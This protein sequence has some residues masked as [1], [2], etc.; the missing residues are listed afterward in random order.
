[1]EFRSVSTDQIHPAT[2]NPRK[3]LRP[4]D[5]DYERLARSI[6]EF[7]CVEPLVWNERTGN[8]VGGHQR[9]NVLRERGI[10]EFEVSVV[11][12]DDDR[13]RALNVALNK[14]TGAWDTRKLA[15]LL[16]ELCDVDDFDVTLTGFDVPEARDLIAGV[17]GEDDADAVE[18]AP[19]GKTT[20]R[21][22]ELILLGDHRL[23]CGD[24]A[25]PSIIELALD[26]AAPDLIHTDPPYNVAYDAKRRPTKTGAAWRAIESDDLD[27]SAYAEFLGRTV[28]AALDRLRPGG[29]AYIWNGH[30]QFGLMHELYERHGCHAS[31]VITWAKES[32]APGFGD[33]NEQTEFCLYGWKRGGKHAFRGPANASTLWDVPRERHTSH[34]TQKPVALAE[35]AIAHGS[36]PNQTVFDPFLGSGTT[37]IAAERLQ[38]R[39]IGLELDPAYCDVIVRRYLAIAK[40]PDPELVARYTAEQPDAAG[41]RS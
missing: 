30:R 13:E 4:G 38:R 10:T 33:Y 25:D 37:L 8:L 22:G 3:R 27:R 26:G 29:S 40:N 32:F 21:P 12:L 31:C 15:E 24:C 19:T 14:I 2:Y 1:M 35:R 18:A 11:D 20:T 28:G 16:D 7:G 17:L 9:F 23:V 41:V 36:G 39:C 5:P 6:D 34:P